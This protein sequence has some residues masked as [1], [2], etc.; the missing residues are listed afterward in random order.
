[1]ELLIAANP[2]TESRLPYLIRVPIG[3]GLVFA[4]SDVWPRTKALY[5][6]RLDITEWPDDAELVDRVECLPINRQAVPSGWWQPWWIWL[7]ANQRSATVST[8]PRRAAL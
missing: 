2:D 4:T 6:H 8:A 1:M 3:G 5:C 7:D